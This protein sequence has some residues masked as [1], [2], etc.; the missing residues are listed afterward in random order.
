MSLLSPV[1]TTVSVQF[2]HAPVNQTGCSPAV[3]Q[4]TGLI[5]GS[6]PTHEWPLPL[7]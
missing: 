3:V 4:P 1:E 6:V 5:K 7:I 2:R